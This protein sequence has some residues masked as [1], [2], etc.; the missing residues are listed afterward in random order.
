LSN[1]FAELGR[2]EEALA[3][4]DEAVGLRRAL[5]ASRP[6][7]FTPTLANSVNNRS[8]RLAELGR[9]EEALAVIDEA[10]TLY[11]A[12]AAARPAAYGDGLARARELRNFILGIG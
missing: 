2:R 11:R 7:A 1:R 8:R 12:L 6:D 5:A 3:A 4:I 10:I 9:R